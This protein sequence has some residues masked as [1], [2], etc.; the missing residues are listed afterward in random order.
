M[1]A[2]D[3]PEDVGMYSQARAVAD[4]VETLDRLGIDKAHCIGLSMGGFAA[5]HFG[6]DHADRARSAVIGGVGFGA[7]PDTA[8]R[9]RAE[10]EAV[11]ER[12]ESEGAETF[13][14]VYGSG[15]GREQLENKDPRGF[16][17]FIAQLK[18]HSARGAAILL[19][20]GKC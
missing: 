20:P 15:A 18:E 9:F 4:I 16:A 11:A 6:L 14:P 19:E 10:V 3:V 1:P 12:W 13:A 2:A 5:M 17:E 8:D 7:E